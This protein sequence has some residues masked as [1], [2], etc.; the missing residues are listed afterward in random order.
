[1]MKLFGSAKEESEAWESYV[2]WLFSGRAN[3]RLSFKD[4]KK[5]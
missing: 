3:H 4:W 5:R 1:M 2:K